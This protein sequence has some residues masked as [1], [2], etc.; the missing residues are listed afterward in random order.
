MPFVSLLPTGSSAG[1][2]RKLKEYH[3]SP[4][5]LPG[6]RRAVGRAE[7]RGTGSRFSWHR[8]TF[9][10][11]IFSEVP[12][13]DPLPVSSLHLGFET[14]RKQGPFPWP[15][16]FLSKFNLDTEGELARQGLELCAV[17]ASRVSPQY[18]QEPVPLS[19]KGCSGKWG[20]L[21][22]VLASCLKIWLACSFL[23]RNKKFGLKQFGS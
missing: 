17:P 2:P 19:I 3:G 1:G 13:E 21:F 20:I 7:G 6:G 18:W 8:D 5:Y 23:L 22:G 9:K 14:S 10:W 12:K 4:G 11:V 15:H 16:V